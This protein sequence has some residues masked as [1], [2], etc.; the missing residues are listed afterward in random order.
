[1]NGK[2]N[3]GSPK[4]PSLTSIVPIPAAY[5]NPFEENRV[6]NGEY[7]VNLFETMEEIDTW[8]IKVDE[9]E[10]KVYTTKVF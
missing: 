2:G 9:P 4:R 1:M 6:I 5:L 8:Q 7:V 3:F 10:I